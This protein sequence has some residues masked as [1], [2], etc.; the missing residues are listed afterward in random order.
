MAKELTRDQRL[1]YISLW[2]EADDEGRFRADPRLLLG[3][4]FP[5]DRDLSESFIED[6]L[7][8]YVRTHRVVLYEVDGELFGWLT[9]FGRYQ[10]PNRPTPS[11]MPAPDKADWLLSESSV[12]DHGAIS[13]A[14]MGIQGRNWE[15]GVRNKELG[16]SP[17]SGKPG[18]ENGAEEPTCT[19]TPDSVVE[20]VP[21]PTDAPTPTSAQAPPGAQLTMD[22]TTDPEPSTDLVP[23]SALQ[24]RWNQ[25][26][27]TPHCPLMAKSRGVGWNAEAKG[28]F[29]ARYME[30]GEGRGYLEFWDEV[31]TMAERSEFVSGRNPK[32]G[33]GSEWDKKRRMDW[34]LSPSKCAKLLE[35]GYEGSFERA[36][37]RPNDDGH[38][39][40]AEKIWAPPPPM[41]DEERDRALQ[42]LESR[43]VNFEEMEAKIKPKPAMTDAE[44]DEKKRRL[45]EQLEQQ[46]G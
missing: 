44:K 15:L 9:R 22:G 36:E 26:T 17:P 27:G 24:D 1:F 43:G 2:N 8:L 10:K 34:V 14:S 13:E 42:Y 25:N 20:I 39:R 41:A 38:P 46:N 4:C 30:L 19:D 3:A 35:G 5:F 40:H 28:H 18:E 29:R 12:I 23:W 16:S 31:V 7:S 21:P 37:S 6:S 45:L 32:L 33:N 11:R